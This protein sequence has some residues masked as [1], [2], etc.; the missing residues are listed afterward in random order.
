[1]RDPN[2]MISL[3]QWSRSGRSGFR[4]D[5]ILLKWD[6]IIKFYSESEKKL[7]KM[8]LKG[9]FRYEYCSCFSMCPEPT[10]MLFAS[11]CR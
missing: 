9:H 1:M 3:E 5:E 11:A 7:K 2:Q 8:T 4:S 6:E 10:N